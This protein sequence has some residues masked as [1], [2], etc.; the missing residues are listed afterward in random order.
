M[1]SN[2]S[3]TLH[4]SAAGSGREE[5]VRTGLSAETLS[6]ALVDNLCFLQGKHPEAAT[7]N[8]WYLALAYTVRDRLLHRWIRSF[9]ILQ[10]V[11]VKVVGYL[12]AEFL[13]GPQLGNS[14]I[15]LGIIEE[16]RA[17]VERVGQDL[18]A[19]LEH[20]EEPGLG[21]GGLGRLAACFLDSLASLQ[22]PAI[23]YGI[24]YEFGSFTQKI[25][26]GWQVEAPDNWLQS[27]NPWEIARPEIS[28][29]VPLGGHTESYTDPKGRYRVRWVPGRIVKGVAHD[30][31]IPG[32]R[33]PTTGLMRLWK[34]EASESLDFR[35]FNLGDYIG[36]VH[37][38]V[39][40]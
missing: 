29:R 19:L 8:D 31:P 16:T 34:A 24:R 40:S 27:G 32:Y 39:L 26:D 23:G 11:D 7:R 28:Y 35:A 1:H 21:N 12:S 37:S 6:R 9:P 30:T 5:D 14:L 33:V 4:L 38:K 3:Q 13:L 36:A 22:I 10:Q 15:D 2:P 20:E 17:A 25:V 18:D